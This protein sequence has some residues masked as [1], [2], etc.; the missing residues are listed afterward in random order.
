MAARKFSVL[1][2]SELEKLDEYG[3]VENIIGEQKIPIGWEH[4]KNKDGFHYILFHAQRDLSIGPINFGFKKYL[5]GIKFN[6]NNIEL[7]THEEAAR[8]D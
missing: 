3:K 1:P 5:S 7:L 2:I 4:W 6:N 8:F